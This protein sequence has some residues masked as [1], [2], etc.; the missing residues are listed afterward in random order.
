MPKKY[1]V[2]VCKWCDGVGKRE[3]AT[4]ETY[5]CNVCDGTG[6]VRVRTEGVSSG[7]R[8]TYNKRVT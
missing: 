4:G 5:I 1:V 2:K 8:T 6:K 7:M 3:T